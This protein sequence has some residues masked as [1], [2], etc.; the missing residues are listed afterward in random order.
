[1][2]RVLAAFVVAGL[3]AIL[4][5][6]P[7][8]AK[9]CSCMPATPELLIETADVVF[10]GAPVRLVLEAEGPMGTE[11]LWQ[12]DVER[13][14]LG[15]VTQGLAVSGGSGGDSACEVPF[16]EA[17]GTVAVAAR[18]TSGHLRTG[19]CSIMPAAGFV[20]ALG[21]GQLPMVPSTSGPPAALI[22]LSAAAVVLALFGL[23]AIV[24]GRGSVATQDPDR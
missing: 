1:M 21:P 11:R 22:W 3:A 17:Y 16:D 14:Y 12:F 23:A 2:Y 15:E 8:P 13:V 9:A 20:A 6:V 5:L 4:L 24:R 10:V 7:D 18:W 19:A